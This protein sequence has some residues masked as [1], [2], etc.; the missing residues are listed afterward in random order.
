VITETPG[1]AP[2]FFYCSFFVA[3][4]AGAAMHFGLDFK[5]RVASLALAMMKEA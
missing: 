3:G 4:M 5:D 2:G 1:L